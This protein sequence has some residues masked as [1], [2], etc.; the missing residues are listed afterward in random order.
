MT[1]LPQVWS[2]FGDVTS[3]RTNLSVETAFPPYVQDTI[4]RQHRYDCHFV[5]P[6]Y[7]I[8]CSTRT[9]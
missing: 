9:R 4:V 3:D 7:V 1:C 6:W 2:D 8:T 5:Q